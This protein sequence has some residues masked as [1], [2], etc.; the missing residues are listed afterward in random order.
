MY[1]GDAGSIHWF[2]T[3]MDDYFINKYGYYTNTVL[4]NLLIFRC[5]NLLIR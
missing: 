4:V 1:I 3:W 5:Y 2:Y